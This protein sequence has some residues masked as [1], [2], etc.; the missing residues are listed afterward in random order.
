MIKDGSTVTF[1]Y[2]LSVEGKAVES[3][4]EGDPVTYV[5]G[6]GQIV[7]GLEK[8]LAG[9]AE[10]DTTSATVEPDDGYGEPDP[11]AV[12]TVPKE[13]FQ[14]PGKVKVGDVV[15]GE[16]GGQPIRATIV[17]VQGDE[18]TVDLNHPLAGKTLEFDVEI[19]GVTP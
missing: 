8:R 12:Q 14:D 13:A 11:A 16:A 5:H 19:V 10:G 1:H 15:T 17:D 9:L 2:T 6:K 7:P 4:R 3:S 18:I